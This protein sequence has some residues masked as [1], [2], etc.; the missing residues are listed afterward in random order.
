MPTHKQLALLAVARRQLGLDEEIYRAVLHHKGGVESARD[1]DAAGFTAVMEYFKACGF[2][3]SRAKSNYGRR[4]GMATPGQVEYIRSL[5]REWRGQDD[6]T[7]LNAWLERSFKVSALRF[8]DAEIAGKAITG[9]RA[10][11]ARGRGETSDTG[12]Q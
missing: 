9:L 4:P 10:M 3:P 7:G 12:T 1:L 8:A 11:V 2:K 6:D 5:W